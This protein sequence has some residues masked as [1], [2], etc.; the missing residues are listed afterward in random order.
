MHV[1]AETGSE[2]CSKQSATCS[3]THQCKRV[4]V[5]LY[6]ACRGTFVNHYINAVVLHCAVQILLYH[7]RQSVYLIDKQHVVLL[8]RCQYSSQIAGLVEHGA[9]GYLESHAQLVRDDV[10]QG[11]L[12]Q[13]W[14]SVQQCVVK[15]FATV[16]GCLYKH[17]QVLN[18]L[19]LSAEVAETQRAQ[20]VLKVFLALREAFLAYIEILV[21]YFL[22]ASSRLGYSF[23][24]SLSAFR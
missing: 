24:C 17:F 20:S 14:R 10:R 7:G 3:G 23:F 18:H 1:N 19:F 8:K 11:G 22:N 12:S 2:R 6:A 4:Q 15:R 21:H 13:S 9:A 5:N 16:F